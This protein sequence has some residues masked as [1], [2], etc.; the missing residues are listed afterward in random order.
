MR[1][2]P[3]FLEGQNEV[4]GCLRKLLT[5]WLAEGAL[6]GLGAGGRHCSPGWVASPVTVQMGQFSRPGMPG[7]GVREPA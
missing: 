2:F 7:I 5:P 4:T 3:H 6:G 1:A